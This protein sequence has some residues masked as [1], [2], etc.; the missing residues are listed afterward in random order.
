MFVIRLLTLECLYSIHRIYMHIYSGSAK[1]PS[2]QAEVALVKLC[3]VSLH[4]SYACIIY[5]QDQKTV[6]FLLP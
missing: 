6:A 4:P 1:Q 5:I 3:G 2:S